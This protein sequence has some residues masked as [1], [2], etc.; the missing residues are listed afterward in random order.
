MNKIAWHKFKENRNELPEWCKSKNLAT[1]V[2]DDNGLPVWVPFKANPHYNLNHLSM[3]NMTHWM[4]LKD[5][6]EFVEK[7]NG[8]W[9]PIKEAKD[10][11]EEDV[12]VTAIKNG[13]ITMT[14]FVIRKGWNIK[15][16]ALLRGA[17]HWMPCSE[18]NKIILSIPKDE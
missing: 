10:E 14:P 13:K 5:F 12:A 11:R 17:T 3:P 8:K 18:Y 15:N 16:P 6:L 4:V 1:V 2:F 9:T 7:S